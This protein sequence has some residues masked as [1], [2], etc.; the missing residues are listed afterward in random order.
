MEDLTLP[1]VGRSLKNGC[2]MHPFSPNAKKYLSIP[3]KKIQKLKK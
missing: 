2:T 3:N 1:S